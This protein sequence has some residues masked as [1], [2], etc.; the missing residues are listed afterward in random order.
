MRDILRLA[1]PITVWL[2]GFSAL[3][4]LQGLACSEHWPLAEAA[5]RPALIA[6]AL[7]LVALQ[8]AMLLALRHPRVASAEPFVQTT[9]LLL[10]ITAL[11]AAAWTA[12]PVAVITICG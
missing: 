11:V 5:R 12:L 2:T 8:A 7:V 6:A 9:A 1:L 3:Y 4:G 10:A